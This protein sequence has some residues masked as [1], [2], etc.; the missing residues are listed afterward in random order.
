MQDEPSDVWSEGFD[1][2]SSKAASEPSASTPSVPSTAAA[3]R[4]VDD[5]DL[6]TALNAVV[7]DSL[8]PVLIG[9][10]ILYLV[11]MFTHMLLL[12]RPNAVYIS[13]MAAGSSV[14]L[15]LLRIVMTEIDPES[16]HVYALSVAASAIALINTLWSQALTQGVEV[17]VMAL[18]LVGTGFVYL[19]TTW[20]MPVLVV[21]LL[22]WLVVSATVHEM[23]ALFF[24]AIGLS[25]SAALATMM[26]FVR[27]RTNLRAERLRRATE[28]QQEALARTLM[29]KERQ[30]RE[31]EESEASLQEALQDLQQTKQELEHREQELSRMVDELT[32]AKEK[33]EEASQLKSAMLANMSH[34]VRTPLTTITGFAEVL[35]EEASG[36]VH[37]FARM[38][39][40]NSQRLLETLSSVLRLS[41]LEAGKENLHFNSLDLV[42]EAEAIITEQ[43]ERAND[44]GVDLQLEAAC[45]TCPCVLD[46]GAVQRILRNLVGNAIKFTDDGGEVI[47]RVAQVTRAAADES[48]DASFTHVRLEVEDTGIGMSE[49]FRKNMFQAFRQESQDPRSSH[50]GS[51]LGLSITKRLVELLHGDIAVESEKGEGTRFTIHLPR[52]PREDTNGAETTASPPTND[53]RTDPSE[54]EAAQVETEAGDPAA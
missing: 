23:T 39:H 16:N 5:D 40:E 7:H 9:L 42:E 26:H 10:S 47:V 17:V 2:P 46:S 51:G 19:S 14:V 28:Q 13:L 48:A 25:G 15:L 44:A 37:Q 8:A 30:Q 53:E 35:T 29:V 3:A 1:L 33:A 18:L 54:A 20:F 49:S 41:K 11:Q 50:K 24:P 32:V 38:I 6:E 45:E 31:L 12:S 43:V 22:C 4:E 27:R 21:S 36:Q 52:D 34:E